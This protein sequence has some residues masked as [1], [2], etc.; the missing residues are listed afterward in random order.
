M[1][2]RSFN[3][4][5]CSFGYL[6]LKCKQPKPLFQGYHL[7]SCYGYE[8]KSQV[9][10]F[11]SQASVYNLRCLFDSVLYNAA[12]L[13][14]RV[15][16]QFQSKIARRVCFGQPERSAKTHIC[17][18]R[19]IQVFQHSLEIQLESIFH[20][21][22]QNQR[23]SRKRESLAC[24]VSLLICVSSCLLSSSFRSNCLFKVLM[25]S[26]CPMFLSRRHWLTFL[27]WV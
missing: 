8:S 18:Q 22:P 6:F 11:K 24:F 27:S 2:I 17:I 14:K 16:S 7:L 15:Q 9:S 3:F 12:L 5:R 1:V 26:S 25:A 23:L 19:V 13:Q 20:H 21:S 4:P 10:F